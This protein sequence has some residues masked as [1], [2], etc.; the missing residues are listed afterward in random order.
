MTF[1]FAL[2]RAAILALATF[3]VAPPLRA[4]YFLLDGNPV[5]V[6]YQAGALL[7]LPDQHAADLDAVRKLEVVTALAQA[8]RLTAFGARSH[9]VAARLSAVRVP[10]YGVAMF[11]VAV[12]GHGQ[13]AQLLWSGAT[14][15]R[16]I[17]LK[18]PG[19]DARLQRTL[20]EQSRRSLAPHYRIGRLLKVHDHGRAA[21]APHL[22][23]V[24]IEWQN[25]AAP[26]ANGGLDEQS[27]TVRTDYVID[28]R[29]RSPVLIATSAYGGAP[30]RFRLLQEPAGPLLLAASIACIDGDAPLMLDLTR[31]TFGTGG[32][33]DVPQP[34]CFPAR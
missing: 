22:A 29:S 8:D 6:R 7:R 34:G 32:R 15:F 5:P 28:K 4:A 24:G 30:W 3:C 9:P 31:D 11:D 16:G 33:K 26:K 14:P 17:V 10:E 12:A 13:G 21:S 20:V 18:R 27:P 23:F 19:I 2:A 25:R 1:S